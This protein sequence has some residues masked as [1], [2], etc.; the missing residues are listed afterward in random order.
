MASVS[1][2]SRVLSRKIKKFGAV[3]LK[4]YFWAIALLCPLGLAVHVHR[5]SKET[6]PVLFF[7]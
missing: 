7:E 3:L 1:L 6:V 5:V 4:I 2:W